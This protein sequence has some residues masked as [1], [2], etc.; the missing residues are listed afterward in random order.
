MVQKG[1]KIAK[2]RQN[3]GKIGVK[4]G[5]LVQILLK[6]PLNLHFE[7]EILFGEAVKSHF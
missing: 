5:I 4:Q 2:I 6:K 7:G 3:K 1:P